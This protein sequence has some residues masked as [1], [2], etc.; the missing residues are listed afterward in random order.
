MGPVLNK[1]IS[2]KDLEVPE[3]AEALRDLRRMARWMW[4]RRIPFAVN[5]IL[6]MRWRIR[7]NKMWEYARG[8]AFGNFQPGM[9]VLDF[10]GGATIPVFYLAR[11]GCEVLSLDINEK[12]ITHTNQVA[13]QRGWNLRGST[14]DLTQNEAPREWGEFDRVI[15]YCVIEH[16]PKDLHRITVSR[17]AGLLKPGGIFELTFDYG[18]NAPV[19]NAV[20]GKEEVRGLIEASGLVV[21]GNAEF[22]DTEER[23]TL[24]NKFPDR[25]FTFGSLFLKRGFTS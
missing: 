23:Y 24:V 18:E 17:L 10:G 2:R 6:R 16:I 25:D 12:F 4:W 5:D 3:V 19:T 11:L 15:S 21:M 13:G 20:R 9:R 14:F 22:F 7:W 8:L 1:T